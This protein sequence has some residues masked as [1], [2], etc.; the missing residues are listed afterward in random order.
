MACQR[1]RAPRSNGGSVNTKKGE[2]KRVEFQVFG[3]KFFL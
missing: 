1:D 2:A 3:V